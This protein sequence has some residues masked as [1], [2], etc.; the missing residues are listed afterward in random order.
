MLHN[1][2]GNGDTLL[3]TTGHLGWKMF[4][5]LRQPYHLQDFFRTSGAFRNAGRQLYIFSGSQGRYQVK[6]LKYESNDISPVIGE[7]PFCHF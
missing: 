5:P 3:L 1:R 2:P 6:K 7:F 4:F